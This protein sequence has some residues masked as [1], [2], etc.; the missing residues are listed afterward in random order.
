[1]KLSNKQN[2]A[3][4][5]LLALA[6]GLIPL[7]IGQAHS[8]SDDSTVSIRHDNGRFHGEVKGDPPRCRRD[9]QVAV[10]ETRPG[11]RPDRFHDSDTTNGDGE[12]SM[13]DG[14]GSPDGKFY[15]VVGQDVNGRYGHR[16]ACGRDR[17]GSLTL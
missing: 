4:G 9:R 14:K 15:A 12:W 16:H 17:S 5:A 7:S 11:D 6:A 1:M 10:F 13:P 2:L 3:A 8:V